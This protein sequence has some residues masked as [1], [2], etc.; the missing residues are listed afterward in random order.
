[1]GALRDNSYLH[2]MEE[3]Y[4][5]PDNPTSSTNHTGR[6]SSKRSFCLVGI[7]SLCL[8]GAFLLA[9]LITFGIY[10]HNCLHDS[11]DH[12]AEIKKQLYSMTEERDLLT[13]K[14]KELKTLLCFSNQYKTCPVG[15][16]KFNHRCYL[17][18][19]RSDSW[20]A[21]RKNCTDEE[22]DLIVIDSPEEKTFLPT[23]I[24]EQTWIGLNDKEQEGTWKWVDGTP[25]TL[26]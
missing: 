11:A 16:S 19:E 5:K 1:M 26:M 4:L 8:L 9:R 12:L 10:Y 6:M 14:T 15:W 7:L 25:P 20:D 2:A 22:A 17:Q 3:I 13:E 21:A 23:I 24:N 18:S